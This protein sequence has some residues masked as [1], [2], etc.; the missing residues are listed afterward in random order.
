M[1]CFVGEKLP[2]PVPVVKLL[3]V[4]DTAFLD[5]ILR[6]IRPKD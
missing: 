5:A 2:I 1:P 3:K 6:H 4:I